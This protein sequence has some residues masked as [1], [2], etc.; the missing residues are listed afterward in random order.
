MNATELKACPF[1]NG[2]PAMDSHRAYRALNDGKIGTSVGI[3]CTGCNAD[4][5]LCREDMPECNGDE[6]M[7]MLA[8]EWNKRAGGGEPTASKV[9]GVSTLAS[10]S[11]STLTAMVDAFLAWPLPDD[12]CAD[13]CACERGYKHRSG[14]NLLDAT[15]ARA[16]LEHV[17]A[18]A[19]NA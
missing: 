1:C 17:L 7:E 13:Q 2:R 4:M 14:T 9:T 15:Q 19:S 10:V 5:T 8:A 6:L 3:Y 16:M 18:V 11:G 12:V